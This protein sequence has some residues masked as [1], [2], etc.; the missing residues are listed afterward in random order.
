VSKRSQKRRERIREAAAGIFARYGVN[1]ATMEDIA[2]AAG[3]SRATLYNYYK[4]K[5]HLFTDTVRSLMDLFFA[6]MR[7]AQS[8]SGT[9][10]ERL[11]RFMRKRLDILATL[12]TQYGLIRSVVEEVMPMTMDLRN[13]LNEHERQ[14]LEG[15]LREGVESGEFMA[16]DPHV[17][18]IMLH[19]CLQGLEVTLLSHGRQ[20]EF[21]GCI[22]ALMSLFIEGLRRR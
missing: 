14:M 2:E 7:T 5:E 11:E 19:G 20:E 16:V 1:K 22:D 15:I 3:I 9:A 12:G 18:A 21:A 6:E 10:S 8:G 13:E 4:D 17:L